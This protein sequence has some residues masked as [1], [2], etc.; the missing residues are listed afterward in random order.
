MGYFEHPVPGGDGASRP[1]SIKPLILVVPVKK[2]VHTIFRPI[3]IKTWKNI[4]SWVNHALTSLNQKMEFSDWLTAALTKIDITRQ[5]IEVWRSFW[6]RWNV[7][8]F[9]FPT[10]YDT[11]TQK[12]FLQIPKIGSRYRWRLI[13][14]RD[15]NWAKIFI[16]KFSQINFRKSYGGIILYYVPFL[17]GIRR[18]HR[19]GQV[20]LK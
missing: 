1:P 7:I 5:R 16:P 11:Y 12:Q 19:P 17:G 14:S 4:P 6:A 8:M 3:S 18:Y 15:Q 9:L 20:G 13:G 10:V 2:W